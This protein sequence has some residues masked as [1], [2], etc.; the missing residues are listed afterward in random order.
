MKRVALHAPGVSIQCPAV[1]ISLFPTL[2]PE[3]KAA[4]RSFQKRSTGRMR[5]RLCKGAQRLS[6]VTGSNGLKPRR[7]TWVRDLGCGNPGKGGKPGVRFPGLMRLAFT[8]A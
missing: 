7:L 2:N 5:N 6:L 8:S 1:A 4:L 3:Q